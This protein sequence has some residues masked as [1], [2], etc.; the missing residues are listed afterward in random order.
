MENELWSR[1]VAVPSYALLRVLPD[2]EAVV[3]NLETEVYFGLNASALRMWE[4]AT[5]APN[6]GAAFETLKED[7]DADPDQ[8]RHDFEALISELVDR[9]LLQLSQ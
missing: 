9:G 3:L 7:F 8:I 1:S 5:A 4:T 2:Q 6:L